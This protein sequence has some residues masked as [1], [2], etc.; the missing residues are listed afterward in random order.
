MND[1]RTISQDSYG[2]SSAV[3]RNRV[4]RNTYWL[5]AISMI[6]TVIGAAIGVYTGMAQAMAASPGM[7]LIVFMVGAFGLMFA[8]EKNKDNSMGVALLLLF[9][10]FMGL[11]LS[12]LIGFVLGFGNGAQLIM[13]PQWCSAPWQPWRRPSNA[14][15]RA[16][17]S[18][19]SWALS[20]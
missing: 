5:L 19:C 18:S 11:M 2:A 6:P 12:R 3:A 20:F 17:A 7:T 15:C 1:Y 13:A 4:L 9:T 8:V 16:W 14:T 10:F